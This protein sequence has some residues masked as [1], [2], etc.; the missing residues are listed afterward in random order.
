MH[1]VWYLEKN[2]RFD[3]FNCYLATPRPT[4]GHYRGVSLSNSVLISALKQLWPDVNRNLIAK[5]GR[6]KP[7]GD[8][9]VKI[10]ESVVINIK[11][12]GLS[13]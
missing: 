5:L 1:I 2:I 12:V 6:Y 11:V 4:F 13:L 9:W 3:I 10:V 7:P 8:L